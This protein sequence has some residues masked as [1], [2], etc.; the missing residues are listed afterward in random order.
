MDK[1]PEEMNLKEIFI[2]MK[3]ISE[4]MVD[5]AYSSVLFDSEAIADE[6]CALEETM[7]E[8]NYQLIIR[9]LLA[10]RT[11]EDAE[12]ISEILN[13]A[14]AI[15][16]ISDHAQNISEIVARD[17]NIHEVIQE[18]L[19][20]TDEKIFRVRLDEQS[21]LVGMSIR[22]SRLASSIGVTVIAVRRGKR[23]IYNPQ[24]RFTFANNDT[25][26]ARGTE[27]GYLILKE[28]AKGRRGKW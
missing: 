27:E 2:E 5:L 4:L 19:K 28:I 24:K 6:V 1:R 16:D 11:R 22:E 18:S 20:H 25:L 15:N 13:V 8:L 3:D 9:A 23:W 14:A 17:L 10:S 26:I 7:D 21:Q 12:Q